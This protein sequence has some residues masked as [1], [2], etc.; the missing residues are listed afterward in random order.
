M[1]FALFEQTRL[2]YNRHVDQIL[3]C[4]L[5]GVC[6]VNRLN[7]TFREI[8]QH[9]TEQPH[10]DPEIYRSVIVKQTLP[11]FQVSN[12]TLSCAPFASSDDRF[13]L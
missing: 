8:V 10:Y 5:Y 12:R 9:Y 11:D 2:F 7:V 3:L 13:A 4:A 1:K 6:K